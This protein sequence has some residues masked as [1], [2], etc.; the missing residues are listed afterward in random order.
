MLKNWTL[1]LCAA[2]TLAACE[3]PKLTAG[4]TGCSNGS[5]C[6]SGLRCIRGR[7]TDPKAAA[8]EVECSSLDDP[9][10]PN[11][12]A[13]AARDIAVGAVRGLRLCPDD[14][15]WFSVGGLLAGDRFTLRAVGTTAE[16]PETL[17]LVGPAGPV[18][19]DD[20]A[21]NSSAVTRDYTIAAEGA[22][23]IRIAGGG[24][25]RVPGGYDL[26]L[27]LAPRCEPDANATSEGAAPL[28]AEGGGSGTL[29]DTAA[30]AWWSLEL[31]A[32]DTVELKAATEGDTA[33]L[34]LAVFAPD[35]VEPVASARGELALRAEAAGIHLVRVSGGEAWTR[36]L[37]TLQAHCANDDGETANDAAGGA[38]AAVAGAPAI[39]VLCPGDADW[40]AAPAVEERGSLVATVSSSNEDGS[41]ELAAYDP[42][43]LDGEPLA[44]T[45]AQG[46][47]ASLDFAV[48]RDLAPLL[49]VHS[50]TD[51]HAAYQIAVEVRAAPCDPDVNLDRGDALA[52]PQG[53]QA[54]GT[55]CG[56]QAEGWW[57]LT[58]NAGEAFDASAQ[59][60]RDGSPLALAIFAGEAEE[61][62]A[63]GVEGGVSLP[64]L[65]AGDY[66]LRVAG[67]PRAGTYSLTVARCLNDG[68]EPDN[69]EPGTAPQA[70]VG[71]DVP[72]SLCPEDADW[73]LGPTLATGENLH[74]AVT[75]ADLGGEL[76]LSLVDP[77]APDGEPLQAAIGSEGRA[78]VAWVADREVT[79]L[80]LVRS[81]QPVRGSYRLTLSI[82]AAPCVDEIGEPDNDDSAGALPVELGEDTPGALCEG[83]EDWW[84]PPRL[85][86]GDLMRVALTYDDLGGDPLVQ[87]W[88][89]D[90][91]GGHALATAAGSDHRAQLGYRAA[92]TL[93]PR[94][95][96]LGGATLRGEYLLTVEVEPPVCEDGVGEP[97]NDDPG[98]APPL[99]AGETAAVICLDD[100]DWFALPRLRSGDRVEVEATWG[101]IGGELDL[102]LFPAD[103]PDG[104][105]LVEDAGA[106]GAAFLELDADADLDA[107]LRVGADTTVRGDYSLTLTVVRAACIDEIDEPAND[108]PATAVGPV[109]QGYAAALCTGDVDWYAAPALEPG[110]GLVALIRYAD[111]G[112]DPG[113][114]VWDPAALEGEPLAVGETTEEGSLRAEHQAG[115][116]ISP[117]VRVTAGTTR[118]DY[119]LSLTVK[120]PDPA[121][122][123]DGYEDNDVF[124]AARPLANEVGG[125][126][127]ALCA[128][129]EDWFGLEAEAASKVTFELR[130][131]GAAIEAALEVYD[132]GEALLAEGAAPV[133]GSDANLAIEDLA[134]PGAMFAGPQPLFVRIRLLSGDGGAYR[135][136]L[137]RSEPG[138]AL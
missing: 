112:G 52:I 46:G 132:E 32:G 55:L 75:Y 74:A 41:F 36:Y 50:P 83:D 131:D 64:A 37:L 13:D 94:I 135:L 79:P 134:V 137:V 30:E 39:G 77:G 129:D 51:T 130:Y 5:D 28:P 124:A 136:D 34:D 86:P 113:L 68:G 138:F 100:V 105:A 82:D 56:P 116:A 89:A 9:F 90:D 58:L 107:V 59:T 72:G 69:D 12:S 76:T 25:A 17:E 66:L 123:E 2:S 122:E 108:E 103:A 67:I 48:A 84:A 62:M 106:D 128:D 27:V 47:E 14:E 22:Y 1:M 115:S 118:G 96:V 20:T 73:H 104:D 127:A 87:V 102:A 93:T 44:R 49:R 65:E 101:D 3:Q 40:F 18:T 71:M 26:E 95:R 81:D 60:D 99:E 23:R 88:D 6:T 80:L 117:L 97:D 57:R 114:E 11:D 7:C 61:P 125:L 109:D 91:L 33:F 85:L 43:A 4:E 24:T 70:G 111:P 126:D 29:C 92:A 121:C 133:D 98:T 78:E 10:E 15:D 42:D 38:A 120:V 63:E 110:D 35:G 54:A 45:D 8:E 21:G 16:P 19:P 31:G 119:V 53:D